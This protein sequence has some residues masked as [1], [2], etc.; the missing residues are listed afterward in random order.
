[1]DKFSGM[2]VCVASSG[3]PVDIRWA[4][5]LPTLI[6]PV[7]MSV[8]WFARQ[9]KKEEVEKGETRAQ[10]RERL[11]EEI[12][13]IGAPYALFLD[14]DTI[15]PP[16]APRYLHAEI[17][18]DP[19]AMVCGG[20]YC[21]KEDPPAPIVFKELGSGPFYN[22]KIGDVFECAGI[23]AGCMLIKTEVFK[24]ISKPWFAEPDEDFSDKVVEINGVSCPL[25]RSTATDD[26]FF[27][28]K[29][30]DAGFKIMAH[31]GVLPVHLDQNGKMYT[32]PLSS[33]PCQGAGLKPLPGG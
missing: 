10:N 33:Y 8:G 26:L 31:G 19:K 25:T 16:W 14:D 21:T 28:K 9:N 2:A 17:N 30:A 6:Y 18:R 29:V 7:G 23:G 20:I 4:L 22:W 13:K 1:M 5:T 32:L 11:M 3:R 12:I 27:C 15:P 24:H